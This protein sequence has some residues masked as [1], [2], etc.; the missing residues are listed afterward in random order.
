MLGA[1]R[2]PQ[3]PYAKPSSWFAKGHVHTW[4][5]SHI[6]GELD[7][8][9]SRGESFLIYFFFFFFSVILDFFFFPGDW[10]VINLLWVFLILL[11][12]C[13]SHKEEGRCAAFIISPTG[14]E[15]RV[16]ICVFPSSPFSPGRPDSASFLALFLLHL[17]TVPCFHQKGLIC[18]SI[19]DLFLWILLIFFIPNE[20]KKKSYFFQY[21][22]PALCFHQRKAAIK[23]IFFTSIAFLIGF[24]YILPHLIHTFSFIQWIMVDFPFFFPTP[25][26]ISLIL[27]HFFCGTKRKDFSLFYPRKQFFSLL[28]MCHLP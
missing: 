10:R 6:Q 7:H 17:L 3:F 11:Y 8:F 13:W 5:W 12:F 1:P 4:C 22:V 9:C 21:F 27:L 18:V 15:D 23:C 16:V 28:L 19:H 24:L 25:P 14:G 2:V 20:K 26:K